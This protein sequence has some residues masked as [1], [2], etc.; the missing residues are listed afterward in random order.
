MSSVRARGSEEAVPDS[1]SPNWACLFL[2]GGDI[3]LP[4]TGVSASSSTLLV[5]SLS[6]LLTFLQSPLTPLS[7]SPLIPIYIVMLNPANVAHVA[8]ISPSARQRAADGVKVRTGN[9]RILKLTY[10][11]VKTRLILCISNSAQRTKR[12]QRTGI[13]T[14]ALALHSLR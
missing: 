14:V 1:Y 13:C 10:A 7:L 2:S 9:C 5:T 6:F 8:P 12:V 3:S 4:Q 11:D